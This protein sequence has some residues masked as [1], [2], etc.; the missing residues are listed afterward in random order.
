M[1]KKLST[2]RCYAISAPVILHVFKHPLY[3][4]T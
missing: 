3:N 4:N 1:P 2:N